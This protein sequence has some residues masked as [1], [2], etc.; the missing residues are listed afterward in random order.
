MRTSHTSMDPALEPHVS[1]RFRFRALFD[2]G[3]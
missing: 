2:G 1:R 3:P